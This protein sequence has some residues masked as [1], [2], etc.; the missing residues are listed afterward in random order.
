VVVCKTIKVGLLTLVAAGLLL[1]EKG[2]TSGTWRLDAAKSKFNAEH[3]PKAATLTIDVS[4]PSIK[5]TYEATEADESHVGYEYSANED[6]GKDYPVS[7]PGRAALLG[8]ADSVVLRH[9]GSNALAVL[10]KKS[11]QAVATEKVVFSKDG[12]IVT[13]TSQGADSKG[14]PISSTTVW[15]RQ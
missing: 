8:G 2:A 13:V 12:K 6:D 14:Q 9:T 4:G 10:Y 5:F 1:A 7:G 15:D 11:G 3:G